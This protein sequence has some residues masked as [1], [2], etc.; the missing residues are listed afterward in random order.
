MKKVFK[1]TNQHIIDLTDESIMPTYARFPIAIE[2]GSGSTLWDFEGRRYIDFTSG[3]GVN[4]IGYCNEKWL[5]ALTQQAGKV[6][7]LPTCFT[8]SPPQ[9]SQRC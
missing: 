1:L 2:K 7:H 8:P 3:I 4:S 5:A 9:S 6:Q